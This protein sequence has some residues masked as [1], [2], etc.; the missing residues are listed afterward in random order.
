MEGHTAYLAGDKVLNPAGDVVSAKVNFTSGASYSAANWDLSATVTAKL[1]STTAASTYRPK[2]TAKTTATVKPLQTWLAALAGRDQ[3]KAVAV[4]IGDSVTEGVGALNIG[5]TWVARFTQQLRQLYPTRGIRD[6]GAGFFPTFLT[7]GSIAGLPVTIAGTTGNLNE[8]GLGMKSTYLDSAGDTITHTFTGTAVDLL[9]LKG[10]TGT[11]RVASYTVDGG[12]ATTFDT[13]GSVASPEDN[14]ILRISAGASG[15]H[16]IVIAYSS[17]GA[18]Y[19]EGFIDYDGDESKGVHVLTAEHGGGETSNYLA[20]PAGETVTR[21]WERVASINPSL[22]VLALGENDYLH[23]KAVASFKSNLL[24]YIA[25]QRAAITGTQPDFVLLMAFEANAGGANIAP[26][27]GYVTAANE[28]AAADATGMIVV[29]LTQRMPA[30]GADTLGLYVDSYHPRPRG[31]QL[32][33][34]AVTE[35]VVPW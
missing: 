19:F 20:V 11:A 33:A 34:R 28:I 25:G 9:Y 2:A 8:N 26:R 1:D 17:G 10:G 29:D 6:G 22:I 5:S 21:H 18:S 27:S 12:S 3:A 4:V 7:S 35:A 24:A 13:Q 32:I 15:S 14:G 16:T 30:V 23:G 31:H